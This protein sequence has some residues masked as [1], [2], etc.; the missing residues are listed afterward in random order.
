MRCRRESTSWTLQSCECSSAAAEAAAAEAANNKFATAE[1]A[2]AEAANNK[3]AIAEAAAAEAAESNMTSKSSSSAWYDRACSRASKA[4]FSD[5]A[6]LRVQ[7]QL[8]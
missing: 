7:E 5:P 3:F 1:A 4:K 2:A 8:A 6:E